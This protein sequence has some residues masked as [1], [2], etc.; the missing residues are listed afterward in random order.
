M[1]FKFQVLL[2]NPCPSFLCFHGQAGFQKSTTQSHKV[3]DV[4]HVGRMWRGFAKVRR[5]YGFLV[6]D[7]ALA[8]EKVVRLSEKVKD[9]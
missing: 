4:G 9:E 6:I 2:V 5:F 7:D 3:A 8:S 1:T